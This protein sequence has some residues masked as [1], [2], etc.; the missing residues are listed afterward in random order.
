MGTYKGTPVGLS[1]DF[2]PEI[3]QARREWNDILKI[4]KDKT[5]QP[6]TLYSEKS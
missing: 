6:R 3:L 5:C 2:S 4:L 1:A